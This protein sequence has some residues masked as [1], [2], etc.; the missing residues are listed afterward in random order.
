MMGALDWVGHPVMNEWAKRLRRWAIVVLDNAAM[1]HAILLKPYQAQWQVWGLEFFDRPAYS[2]ELNRIEPLG[3][4]SNTPGIRLNGWIS[5]F[6][7]FA[8]RL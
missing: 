8:D 4:R 7:P 1:H 3:S 5:I 6:V 2:L